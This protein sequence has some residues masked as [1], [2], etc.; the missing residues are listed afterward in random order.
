MAKLNVECLHVNQNLELFALLKRSISIN[1]LSTQY[2]S[3]G[4]F[5]NREN[6]SVALLT[7][8]LQM[9]L[10]GCAIIIGSAH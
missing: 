4:L 9:R 2:T 8:D 5:A 10:D 3:E 1:D 6:S 7:G